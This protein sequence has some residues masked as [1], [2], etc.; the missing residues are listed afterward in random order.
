MIQH[1]WYF[2]TSKFILILLNSSIK[3]LLRNSMLY[4]NK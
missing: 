2:V 4:T 3:E 1:S